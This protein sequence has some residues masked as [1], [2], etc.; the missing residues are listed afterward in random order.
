MQPLTQ[1]QRELLGSLL[2]V[3]IQKMKYDEET[4]WGADDDEPEEEVLFT[5]LRK[6]RNFRRRRKSYREWQSRA[7][8]AV[9]H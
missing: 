2:N 4:E 3:I 1:A 6:V 7:D 5:E 8:N 9:Y